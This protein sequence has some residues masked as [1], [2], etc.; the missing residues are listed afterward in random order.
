MT[1]AG[2]RACRAEALPAFTSRARRKERGMRE[3]ERSTAVQAPPARLF[4]YL[5]DVANLAAY[6]PRL[7]SATP[8]HNDK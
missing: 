8:A 4:S 2:Q 3:Y 7:I 6:L 5:A 1:L